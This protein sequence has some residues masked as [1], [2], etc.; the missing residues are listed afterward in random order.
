MTFNIIAVANQSKQLEFITCERN[1]AI[2]NKDNRGSPEFDT[3]YALSSKFYFLNPG[4][5]Q[6]Y[7]LLQ[8]IKYNKVDSN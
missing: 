7:G 3:F 5:I 1:F 4:E 6:V 2:L 8:W